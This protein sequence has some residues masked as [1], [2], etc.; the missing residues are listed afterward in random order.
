M[1]ARSIMLFFVT[2]YL[3]GLPVAG[4]VG[5]ERGGINREG[6]DAADGEVG[7]KAGQLKQTK[8][9]GGVPAG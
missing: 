1:I 3:K 2:I 5:T 9:G 7:Q 6:E 4:N 8:K